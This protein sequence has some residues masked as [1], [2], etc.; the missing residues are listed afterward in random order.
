MTWIASAAPV[1]YVGAT[2]VFADV[3]EET[4]CLSR[5][6][7][8]SENISSRTKAVIAV[9]LYGGMPDMRRI[10][11]ICRA[12]GIPIIED[13]AQAIGSEIAGRRAGS[14]G[15]VGVF[16]FHGSKTM[17]T[18]EGGMLVTDRDDIWRRGQTAARSRPESRRRSLHE[19]G[20]RLQ[21][22]DELDA[23]RARARAARAHRRAGRH[24]AANL[25]VVPGGARRD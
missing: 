19:R 12:R 14:F 25:R 1:T 24:E 16:S 2:P 17:T 18:G 10:R 3:D 13:A 21:V 4:W 6:R 8:W 11:S 23:G 22:Q 7:R 20:D 5:R 9:D 15:D